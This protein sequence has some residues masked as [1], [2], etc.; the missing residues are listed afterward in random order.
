MAKKYNP[1]TGFLEDNATKANDAQPTTTIAK[2]IQATNDSV[3]SDAKEI[4]N[5]LAQIAQNSTSPN[6]IIDL[7]SKAQGKLMMMVMKN[8]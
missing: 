8:K 7:V 3:E 2:A 6:K 1:W 5:I 4:Y